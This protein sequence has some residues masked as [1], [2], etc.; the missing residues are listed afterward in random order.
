[1]ITGDTLPF[2][3]TF[4]YLHSLY[5]HNGSL[6]GIRKETDMQKFHS[7]VH[8]FIQH[9]KIPVISGSYRAENDGLFL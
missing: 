6:M 8:S 9:L 5:S 1:M 7:F 3:D 2:N 4:T